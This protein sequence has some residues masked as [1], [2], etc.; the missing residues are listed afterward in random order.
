MLTDSELRTLPI[1]EIVARCA[2]LSDYERAAVTVCRVP[3]SGT[4]IQREAAN[5]RARLF[6]SKL[7]EM[8]EAVAVL[9]AIGEAI[10]TVA[11]ALLVAQASFGL[12]IRSDVREGE[13]V[14]STYWG[15]NEGEDC[16]HTVIAWRSYKPGETRVLARIEGDPADTAAQ[17]VERLIQEANR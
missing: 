14:T 1:R 8:R 11:H 10:A 4:R 6:E 3:T 12:H 17:V 5:S 2:R 9:L 7:R 13:G 16:G 15:P